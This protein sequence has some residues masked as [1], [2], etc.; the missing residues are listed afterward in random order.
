VPFAPVKKQKVSE[1]VAESIRDAIVTGQMQPSE[2]LPSER[3]LAES[4]GVNRS[5]VREALH[6]LE[7]WGLVQVRQGATTVVRNL[8]RTAGPELLPFLLA[9]GGEPDPKVIYDLLCIRAMILGWTARQAALL[10]PRDEDLVL[11]RELE[12]KLEVPGQTADQL[13]ILDFDYFQELV[14]LTGNRVLALFSNTIR[15]VYLEKPAV[16]AA[17]YQPGKFDPTPHRRTLAAIAAGDGEAAARAMEAH[18][19]VA[20]NLMRAARLIPVKGG[21]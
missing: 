16:F 9:P 2:S 20:L 11:L 13:Q 17:L 7:A 5:S 4:F 18:A 3:E 19:D 15:H 6:R 14:N 21:K 10:G 1:Q 8:L 12:A